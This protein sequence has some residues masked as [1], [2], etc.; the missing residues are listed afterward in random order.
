MSM[1]H[2]VAV[3]VEG[4]GVDPDVVSSAIS[5]NLEPGDA[6]DVVHFESRRADLTAVVAQLDEEGIGLLD[7]VAAA[8][9]KALGQPTWSLSS[10]TGTA[11]WMSV[12]AFASNGTEVWH[13]ET[14]DEITVKERSAMRKA[15]GQARGVEP[16]DWPYWRMM[17]ELT[18]RPAR[19]LIGLGLS[20]ALDLEAPEWKTIATTRIEARTPAAASP[21]LRAIF[22]AHQLRL[23]A[24]A[25][26][27]QALREERVRVALSRR[28]ADAA[29]VM[30]RTLQLGV[31]QVVQLPA[32]LLI[33]AERLA[34]KYAVQRAWVLQ[35]ATARATPWKFP[36]TALAACPARALEATTL[37]I[38]KPLAKALEQSSL[39]AIDGRAATFDELVRVALSVGLDELTD[40]LKDD[41]RK[42][43]RLAKK[44]PVAP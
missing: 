15:L 13:D 25:E 33:K 28:D 22:S 14:R 24:Q 31:P 44:K 17:A 27:D 43:K 20:P 16:I 29:A 11:Q 1:S 37:V 10:M 30:N 35:A 2:A 12:T 8:L 38:S 6:V 26:E 19:D 36:A 40:D 5:K 34:T 3:F 41:E 21:P 4:T 32:A 23:L 9:S 39:P 7:H 18:T 42:R